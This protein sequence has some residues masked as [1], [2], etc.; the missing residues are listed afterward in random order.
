VKKTSIR[1]DC[2]RRLFTLETSYARHASSFD[3]VWNSSKNSGTF[4]STNFHSREWKFH[5]GMWTFAPKSRCLWN[6]GF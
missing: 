2:D 4:V 1:G 6:I 3:A 5:T